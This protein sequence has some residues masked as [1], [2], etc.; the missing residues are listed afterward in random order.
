MLGLGGNI[1]VFLEQFIYIMYDI[2]HIWFLE[3]LVKY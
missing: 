3:I 2:Y 1:H